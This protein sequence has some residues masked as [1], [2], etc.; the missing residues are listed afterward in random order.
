MQIKPTHKPH[1]SGKGV[2]HTFSHSDLIDAQVFPV[3]FSVIK[4]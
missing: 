2:S 1:P 4:S 3:A